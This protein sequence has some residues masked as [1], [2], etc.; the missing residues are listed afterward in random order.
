M[1]GGMKYTQAII[2]GA[3]SGFGAEFARRLAPVCRRLVLVARRETVLHGLAEELRAAH[4]GLEVVV[5]PCDLSVPEQRQTLIQQLDILPEGATLLVNN[6]GLGDYG[7]FATSTP[8]RNNSLLQVNMLAVVELTRA[9]LPRLLTQGGGI[10]NISSLAADLPIP[11]FAL[12]AASK[13]FVAS[14][15]EALRLELKEKGIPVACICPGPVH[16]EFGDVARREGRSDGKSPFR[17]GFYT[18]TPTVVSA[19]LRAVEKGKAR[20]YPSFKVRMAGL[21]VRN[22]PLWLLR[23]VMGMRPRKTKPLPPS[24]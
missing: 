4:E 18:E 20:T 17:K 3:S 11:D 24:V 21:L 8:E 23:L 10:I 12:Y 22:L 9:V 1:I 15:S 2:T 6:A 16:T 7:E 5:Q 14:F 13:A 19:A